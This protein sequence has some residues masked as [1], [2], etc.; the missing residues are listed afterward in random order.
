MVNTPEKDRTFSTLLGS[1][2]F[3]TGRL[4]LSTV[5]D[6]RS[7]DSATSQIL[8]KVVSLEKKWRNESWDY[9]RMSMGV[10]SRQVFLS[11]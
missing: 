2:N 4:H 7:N 5:Q 10:S 6:P 8:V 9:R 3:R 11:R 1:Y